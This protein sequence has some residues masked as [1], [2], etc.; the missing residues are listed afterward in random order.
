MA[1]RS[2]LLDCNDLEAAQLQQLPVTREQNRYK[3]KLKPGSKGGHGCGHSTEQ[4]SLHEGVCNYFH[5][6]ISLNINEQLKM[7][8]EK[9]EMKLRAD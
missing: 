4:D 8:N 2:S 1:L 5:F 9:L 3:A 6:L 7:W